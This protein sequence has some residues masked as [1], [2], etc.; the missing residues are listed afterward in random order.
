[1]MLTRPVSRLAALALLFALCWTV[2]TMGVIPF[3]QW[4]ALEREEVASTR[5]LLERYRQLEASLPALQQQ[6]EGLRAVAG[7]RAFLQSKPS[8]LMT[9]EMQGTAQK[10]ASA[11]GV[12]LRSSRTL[13]LTSE[14]GFNRVGVELDIT[15]SIAALT[16]LLHSVEAAEPAIFVERL[17][18]QV[19]ES[20]IG[21]RSTDG[22]PLLTASLRLNSYAPLAFTKT[23]LP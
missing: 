11:A 15:A 22:Q 10:L 18:V 21:A 20:G 4:I 12:T 23:R 5:T 16:T 3:V 19:P 2:V 8:A 13:P 9:A 1:M 6:L 7:G 17:A 14:E